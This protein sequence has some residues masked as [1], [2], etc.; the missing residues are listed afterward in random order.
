MGKRNT[1]NCGGGGITKDVIM[2]LI[3]TQQ[4]NFNFQ[5]VIEQHRD[6]KS[7]NPTSLNTTRISTYRHIDGSIR[8]LY[9]F[10]RF[11]A[12]GSV[13]DNSSAGGGLVALNDKGVVSNRKIV[14][15]KSLQQEVLS[16]NIVSQIPYF[17][18]MVACAIDLHKQLP[19]FCLVGWD[20]TVTDDGVPCLIEFNT[21]P[22]IEGVQLT[23]GPV[24]TKKELDDLMPEII[25]WKSVSRCNISVIYPNKEGYGTENIIVR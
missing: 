10:Q 9:A 4:S 11:G 12:K 22:S 20:F 17:D 13:V 7:F 25:K 8:L 21:Q 2:D 15:F 19:Y 1:K 3:N 5:E 14:H 16:D 24:W 18:K 6:I 23:Q